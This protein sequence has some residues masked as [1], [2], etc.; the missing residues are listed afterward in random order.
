MVCLDQVV[1]TV[2]TVD[3]CT[4]GLVESLVD[5]ACDRE[6]VARDAIFKSLVDIGRRKH[7]VVLGITHG[8]LTKHNKV[9]VESVA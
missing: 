5:G 7:N 6:Q 9:P 2:V 8:Y 4:P 1:V 3:A